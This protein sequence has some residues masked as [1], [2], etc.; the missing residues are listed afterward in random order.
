M[1]ATDGQADN[2]TVSFT[3]PLR[4]SATCSIIT[5]LLTCNSNTNIDSQTCSFDGM[6]QIDCASPFDI[7]PLNLEQSEHSVTIFITDIFG[8]TDQSSFSFST[9]PTQ[10]ITLSFTDRLSLFEGT[11]SRN[12][13]LF[14]IGG[15]AVGD[16]PFSVKFLT[17]QAFEEMPGPSLSSVFSVIPSAASTSMKL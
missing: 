14:N 12:P 3:T 2:V 15:Q 16:I 13:S 17:Y 8:Q 6:P 4:L 11:D 10:P 1:T 7:R 9:I 5:S